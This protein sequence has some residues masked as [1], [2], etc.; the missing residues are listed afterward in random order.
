MA[1]FANRVVLITG[2]GSGIGRQ[3]A[4]TL[5]AE[6]AAVAALDVRPEGLTTLAAELNGRQIATAV[7][8]VTDRN[9][10][11]PAVRELE[12]RLGPTDVLI[13][14]AGIGAA[15]AAHPYNAEG[16]EAQRSGERAILLITHYQRILNYLKP[17][18]VHVMVR[19]K[20]VREGGPE[21]A[22]E[23]EARGYD[24]LIKELVEA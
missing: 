16:I 22:A 13:A 15:T 5:A 21:L 14:N 9:S 12:G 4:L 24:P 17:D 18:V 2:A 1:S 10:L 3:M 23:L 19:G 11:Y 7:G 20:V 8:D 6:G